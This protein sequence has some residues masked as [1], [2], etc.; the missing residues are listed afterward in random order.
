MTALFSPIAAPDPVWTVAALIIVAAV[1]A[2][3]ALL[4]SGE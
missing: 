1:L 4:R 2:A 3:G